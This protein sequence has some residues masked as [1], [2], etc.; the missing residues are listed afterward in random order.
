MKLVTEPFGR[1]WESRT[2][3]LPKVPARCCF[4]LGLHVDAPSFEAN[5]APRLRLDSF[6]PVNVSMNTMN[7]DTKKRQTDE[8]KVH[9]FVEPR[10]CSI[11]QV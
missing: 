2:Y 4:E 8:F 3:E 7:T 11:F 1:R 9:T 5:A 10:E 6:K